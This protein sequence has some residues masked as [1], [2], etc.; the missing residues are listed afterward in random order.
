[1]PNQVSHAIPPTVDVLFPEDRSNLAG[2]LVAGQAEQVSLRDDRGVGCL[3]FAERK[4]AWLDDFEHFVF[5]VLADGTRKAIRKAT[6]EDIKKFRVP[7]WIQGEE[8]PI[9]CGRE[10]VFVG[11]LDDNEICTE[12]PENAKLWWH[13]VASFYVFTCPQCLECAAVGQQF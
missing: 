6:G 9:C 12:P 8:I 4:L 10:M 3:T 13:D 7:I 2:T 1:M 5:Q 11:Q